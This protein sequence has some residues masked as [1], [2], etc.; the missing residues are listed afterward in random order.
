MWN[1]YARNGV[2]IKTT[3]NCVTAAIEDPDLT[4]LLV[5]DVQYSSQG[6]GHPLFNNQEYAKRPFLFKS[7]SYRYEQE[8]RLVFRVN[9]VA[10]ELE[11]GRKVTVNAEKLLEG[12][13]VITSPFMILDEAEA[14]IELSERFLPCSNVSFRP[15]SE[16]SPRSNDPRVEAHFI[17]TLVGRCG[18]YTQEPDLPDLLREL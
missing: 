12:G 13:E 10:V 9:A 3:L 14:L 11:S 2:A 18:P 4:E 5:A 7:A 6:D 16:R 15:S 1:L 8:V 17:K